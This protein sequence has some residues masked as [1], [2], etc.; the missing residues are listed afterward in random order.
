MPLN[1]RDRDIAIRTIIGEAGNQ[2]ALGQSAVA[3]VML[4]R[5]GSGDFG[6]SLTEVA[7]APGQFDSWR[8]QGPSLA[9][10]NPQS[11]QYQQVGKLLD[12]AAANR[13]DDPTSGATYFM[14]PKLVQKTPKWAQGQG[15]PIGDHTF[16]QPDNPNYGNPLAA[17]RSAINPQQQAIDPLTAIRTAINP[18]DNQ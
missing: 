12:T 7:L 9:A 1:N 8:Q 16:Y 17:I 10:I 11:P 4:N 5:L 18:P 6:K 13:D 3:H 14:N 2:P 15:I